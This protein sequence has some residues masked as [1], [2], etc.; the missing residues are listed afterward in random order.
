MDQAAFPLPDADVLAGRKLYGND[1]DAA[2]LAAWFAAE[3]YGFYELYGHD[4]AYIDGE[5]PFQA[6]ARSDAARLGQRRFDSVLA[7]GCADGRELAALGL[8]IGKVIA[9]E[10]AERF[11]SDSLAGVPA[12]FRKPA[13]DGSLALADGSVDLALALHV[14]HHV[15]NVGHVVA[16]MS[17]VLKPGGTLLLREPNA[18][19]GDFTRPRPGLTQCE[20]GIPVGLMKGFIAEAGLELRQVTYRSTP[21]LPELA[22]KLGIEAFNSDALVWL[23]E[24]LCKLTRFNDRYW[25]P[26]LWHKLAPRSVAYVAVKPV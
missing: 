19:M 13:I 24:Q 2:R 17:R 7:I 22:G 9:V 1:F 25:R 23:D 26:R 16:E 5:F 20:R 6:W 18:S 3:E 21:G 12:E 11:W 15:A 8:E 14:L 10:P 4:N